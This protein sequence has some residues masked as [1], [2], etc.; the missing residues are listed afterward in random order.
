[1]KVGCCPVF[2]FNL[3]GRLKLLRKPLMF[4]ILIRLAAP[5]EICGSNAKFPAAQPLAPPR[6]SVIAAVAFSPGCPRLFARPAKVLLICKR[7][8]E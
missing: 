2:T 4:I 7:R 8:H 5:S 3:C 1:M 6:S